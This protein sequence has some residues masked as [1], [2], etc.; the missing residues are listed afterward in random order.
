M[1]G[2]VSCCR[3]SATHSSTPTT[4][5]T[6]NGTLIQKAQC[7]EK[8]VVSHPPRTGPTAAIEP[9]VDPHTAKAMPR[10]APRKVA[11]SDAR[12]VGRIIDPPIPC[13]NRAAI[14]QAPVGASAHRMLDATNTASPMTSSLRRPIRSLV[15]PH[16]SS[17]AANTSV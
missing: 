14:S 17:S 5:S 4:T 7:H 15:V 11:L 2:W 16:T 8:E 13:T 10:S 6:P 1:N 12:V 3:D 9:I